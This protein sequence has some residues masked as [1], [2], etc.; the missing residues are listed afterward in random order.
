MNV[1]DERFDWL[2]QQHKPK[3][4]VNPFLEVVDIAGHAWAGERVARQVLIST[5]F[6]VSWKRAK[7]N[8]PANK[9][10]WQDWSAQLKFDQRGYYEIW[11]RAYDDQ[12]VAQPFTQPWNPKG[13][14]GNVIHRV[15]VYCEA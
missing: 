10:A 3:S 12:G 13:Y 5:D 8:A 7:L 15:P 14:L 2:V 1:P 9:Y 11:A 4:I 6:G